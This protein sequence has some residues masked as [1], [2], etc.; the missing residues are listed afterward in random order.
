MKR[1]RNR[2][3]SGKEALTFSGSGFD[4]VEIP[5]M[6]RESVDGSAVILVDADS[7]LSTEVVGSCSPT[8]T[9]SVTLSEAVVGDASH[10]LSRLMPYVR[11]E[12]TASGATSAGVS[13]SVNSSS[14]IPPV[15][16]ET[17]TYPEVPASRTS[18]VAPL[19]VHFDAT[20][21]LIGSATEPLELEYWW[22]FDDPSGSFDGGRQGM[23]VSHVFDAPGTYDVMMHVRDVLGNVEPY[24]VTITVTDPDTVFSGTNTICVSTDGVFTGAPSGCVQVTSNDFDATVSTYLANGKRVLFKRGQ[25]F[26]SSATSTIATTTAAILGA[27]GDSGGVDSRGIDADAPIIQCAHDNDLFNL[28]NH[29][30]T[31]ACSDLRI[32]DLECRYTN[33]GTAASMIAYDFRADNVL[34]YR[35]N[36]STGL[37]RNCINL[38]TSIPDFYAVDPGTLIF[39]ANCDFAGAVD[40]VW[41]AG[42]EKYSLLNSDLGNVTVQ[43]VARMQWGTKVHIAGCTF[44]VPAATKHSLTVRAHDH[45][46]DADDSRYVVIDGCS[47][48][49][50]T[51]WAWHIGSESTGHDERVDDVLV[52]GCHFQFST[53]SNNGYALHTGSRRLTVSNCTMGADSGVGLTSCRFLFVATYGSGTQPA[54]EGIRCVH[55]TVTTLT[56]LTGDWRLVNAT[57]GDVEVRNNI[58]YAPSAGSLTVTTGAATFTASN[59]LSGTNPSFVS[60]PSDLHLQSGSA[61]R[62]YGT[63]VA[64]ALRDFEGTLRD[65]EVSPDAGAFEYS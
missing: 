56:S 31:T 23:V 13:F 55:N 34:I 2:R 5:E 62:N 18:G 15:A 41:Y 60:P 53:G 25:T 38:S 37:F 1:K 47:T 30:T 63:P 57:A 10:T 54:P 36:D 59:N 29:S 52:T 19:A 32:M 22:D 11:L 26:V 33:A 4:T 35:V 49:C 44:G 45:T 21:I 27:W 65:Y 40:Y 24:A 9:P 43:H 64:W 61:A 14:G 42:G 51:V 50:G 7:S 3:R 20:E 12:A 28:G 46:T 17:P 8:F 58:L 39:V 6:F 48:T 16:V